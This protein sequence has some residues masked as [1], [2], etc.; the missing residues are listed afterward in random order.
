M[1]HI[2]V[3]FRIVD[4][5]KIEPMD[6]QDTPQTQA[7]GNTPAEAPAPECSVR[8]RTG[9]GRAGRIMLIF[10]FLIPVMWLGALRICVMKSGENSQDA[11]YHAMM[12]KLGPG[13]Y[14]AKQFPWTQM[15]VWKDHF[16]DKELLY[17]AG[18]N[19]IF[20][21]EEAFGAAVNPP[22]HAAA[23]IFSALAILGC[24]FAAWRLGVRP[25]A[26]EKNGAL[27]S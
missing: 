27:H 25:L 6:Q 14:A 22:F 12:A 5:G 15:S 23:L 3:F 9:I 11:L 24:L 1:T 21:I 13:V 8:P 7:L 26:K 20:S 16:A 19:V 17:H 4:T 18:L 10:A 2:R